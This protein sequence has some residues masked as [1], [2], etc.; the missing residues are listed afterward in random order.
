MG[1]GKR[2]QAFDARALEGA[3]LRTRRPGDFIRPFG[4]RGGQKLKQY[5]ID[6]RIDRPF[7]DLWPVLARGDEI[8]WVMGVGAS[9]SAAVT[10]N[11][12]SARLLRFSGRLPDAVGP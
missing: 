2:T 9:Q 12:Q 3:V 8:L 1:D 6:R 11:T 10:E 4:M 7:R 5:F